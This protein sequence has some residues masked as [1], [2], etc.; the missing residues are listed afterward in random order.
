MQ[1]TRKKDVRAAM[2]TMEEYVWSYRSFAAAFSWM[3]WNAASGYPSRSPGPASRSRAQSRSQST[4]TEFSIACAAS[5]QTS[6][7]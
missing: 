4:P 5:R 2:R 1:K 3:I 7:R 6:S